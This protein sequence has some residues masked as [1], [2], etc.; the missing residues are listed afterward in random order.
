MKRGNRLAGSVLLGTSV[1]RDP[2]RHLNVI[3][4]SSVQADRTAVNRVL[5]AT[6]VLR[7]LKH[8]V[9]ALVATTVSPRHTFV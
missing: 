5:K 3:M 9:N 7:G 4:V 8:R 2:R 1:W 6:S